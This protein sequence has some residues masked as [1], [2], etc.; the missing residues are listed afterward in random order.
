[1]TKLIIG[2]DAIEVKAA[3]RKVLSNL[4][5]LN[6][7]IQGLCRSS[8]SFDTLYAFYNAKV[9]EQL[10]ILAWFEKFDQPAPP[11]ELSTLTAADR[12]LESSWA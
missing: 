6:S 2:K 9:E 4:R 7:R 11:G 10:S 8:A 1:M 12:P 3:K 5:M